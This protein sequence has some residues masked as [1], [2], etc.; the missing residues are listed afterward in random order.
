M[1]NLSFALVLTSLSSFLFAADSGAP[2]VITLRDGSSIS[3]QVTESAGGYYLI[4]SPALGDIKIRTSDVVSIKSS[5]LQS[6]TSPRTSTGTPGSESAAPNR[7]SDTATLQSA[8][9]SKVQNFVSSGKGMSLVTQF[10][11]NPDLKA[12][13][14]DPNLMKAIQSGDSTA[15][16]NSPAIKQLMEN[17]QTKSLIQSILGTGPSTSPK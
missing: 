6:A 8:L 10:S 3:A 5:S 17:P 13:M 11:Q 7:P 14:A 9:S 2:Q 12:V 1:K 15:L 16:M 4:K